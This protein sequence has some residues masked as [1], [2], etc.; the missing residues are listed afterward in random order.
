MTGV[1]GISDA[2][3]I[4]ISRMS[5]AQ[6]AAIV[7]ANRNIVWSA[8]PVERWSKDELISEVVEF[9]AARARSAS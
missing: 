2:R 5:K 7:R 4:E 3:V 8:K 1:W 9:E 6:L